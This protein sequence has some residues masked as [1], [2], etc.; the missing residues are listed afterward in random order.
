MAK[1]L[2][3]FS[4]SAEKYIQGEYGNWKVRYTVYVAA[5]SRKQAAELYS[6][7]TM[8]YVTESYVKDYF[9]GWGTE[10]DTIQATVTEPGVWAV[11]PEYS[12]N[13]PVKVL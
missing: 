12:K 11:T 3:F 8:K 7:A 5:Y 6:K 2:K 4:H 9:L 1:K 13:Q 10:M